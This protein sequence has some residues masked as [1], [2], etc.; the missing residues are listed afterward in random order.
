MRAPR[1]VFTI[2]ILTIAFLAASLAAGAQPGKVPRIGYLVITGTGA[3]LREGLR[4]LRYVEG[5]TIIVEVRSAQGQVDRISALAAELVQ[6]NVDVL[7]VGGPE[8]LEAARKVTS[9]IPIVMVSQA[10]PVAAG[11]VTSLAQPGGN[12][13]GL[14][15]GVPELAGK[16]LEL[17]RDAVPGLSR[18]AILWDPVSDPRILREAESAA[19]ALGIQVQVLT[20]RAPADLEGALQTATR[21]RAEAVHV[22]ES[23]MLFS[24]RAQLAD[25]AARSGLPLV[26]TFRQSAQAGYLITYGPDMADLFRRS[27]TYVDKILKGA[28]PGDLPVDQPTKFELVV[29]LKTAKTLGLTIPQSV[30][31]RADE[32]IQ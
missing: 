11:L 13:T 26:G 24:H 29:N 17:L 19:R 31:L 32:V 21:G 6:R 2:I 8:P 22:T 9:S 14:T 3:S 4:A 27:A 23:A 1:P 20:V 7:V 12:I 28:K 16:R 15:A 10:D 18:V 25:L 30:L 5:K